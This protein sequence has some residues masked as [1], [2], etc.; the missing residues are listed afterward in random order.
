[1]KFGTEIVHKQVYKLCINQFNQVISDAYNN[2]RDV[3]K[4]IKPYITIIFHRYY[5]ILDIVIII[6]SIIGKS[7][8]ENYEV[9]VR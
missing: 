7:E 4:L 6:I 1:V 9:N 8:S 3:D 2:Y 5:S